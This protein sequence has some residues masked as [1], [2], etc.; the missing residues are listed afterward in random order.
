LIQSAA[1]MASE[2]AMTVQ[3]ENTIG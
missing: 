1:T 3:Q 2:D